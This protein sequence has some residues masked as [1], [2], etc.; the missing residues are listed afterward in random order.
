MGKGLLLVF[1]AMILLLGC[2]QW[3]PGAP[4]HPMI[5]VPEGPGPGE[6][7]GP[8]MPEPGQPAVPEGRGDAGPEVPEEPGPPAAVGYALKGVSLSPRSDEYFGQFFEE[9]AEAGEVV[10]WA[11]DWMEIETGGAPIVV[12][13]LASA[14]GY[15]PLVEVTYYTQGEGELVRPLTEENR[16]IYRESTMAFVEEYRPEYFVMGIETDIMHEKSPDDYY[17]FVEFYNEMYDEIKGVS[18]DTKVFTVFQLEGMKGCTLWEEASCDPGNSRWELID[19]FKL[20]IVGFSTYPCLVYK[21]PADIPEGHY[22]EINEHVSKPIAFTENGWHS[23]AYPPEWESSEEEQARYVERFF[24]LTEDLD[25]EVTIWSFMY[26]PGTIK[27]FDSMGLRR[28]DGT[29]R[30]AWD[31]WVEGG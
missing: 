29:A 6:P 25:V 15:V 2:A 10:M 7:G 21:D 16:R 17:E 24:G 14:Y 13:G 22:A 1:A 11:G 23:E 20:D 31:A 28:D 19:D 26:G 3:E 12:S 9:A 30:P 18:P 27:P 5:E 4:A 8:G